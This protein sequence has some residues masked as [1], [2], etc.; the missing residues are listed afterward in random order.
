MYSTLL[1]L[2]KKLAETQAYLKMNLKSKVKKV[3]G[4]SAC[5]NVLKVKMGSRGNVELIE[6]E[7]HFPLF[8]PQFSAAGR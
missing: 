7:A 3:A 6:K 1:C 4:Q 8:T 5:A 2:M